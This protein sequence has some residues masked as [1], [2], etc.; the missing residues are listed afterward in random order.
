MNGEIE[1]NTQIPTKAIV[2]DFTQIPLETISSPPPVKPGQTGISSYGWQPVQD[3]DNTESKA[4]SVWGDQLQPAKTYRYRNCTSN[5]QN[6]EV[7]AV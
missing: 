5:N 6:S 7:L 1:I 2:S 4:F 3:K